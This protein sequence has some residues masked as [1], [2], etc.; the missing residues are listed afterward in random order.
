MRRYTRTPCIF[1][2]HLSTL[3]VD[4][5]FNFRNVRLEYDRNLPGY[6]H[7]NSMKRCWNIYGDRFWRSRYLRNWRKV[8]PLF[9][10]FT[11]NI[12]T[13]LRMA[14]KVKKNIFRSS[15]F[16]SKENDWGKRTMDEGGKRTKEKDVDFKKKNWSYVSVYSI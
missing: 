13:V 3:R 1:F 8:F 5:I 16:Q 11:K 14:R 10:R 4:D 7:E 15:L 6:G 9:Y 12:Y 2:M